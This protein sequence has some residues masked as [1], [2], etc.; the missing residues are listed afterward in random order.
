MRVV[1]SGTGRGKV[2]VS[3]PM[4]V[5][6]IAALAALAALALQAVAIAKIPNGSGSDA[7][8]GAV[9]PV[10]FKSDFKGLKAERKTFQG[11]VTSKFSRNDVPDNV[12]DHAEVLAKADECTAGVKVKLYR[13]ANGEDVLINDDKTNKH[14]VFDIEARKQRGKHYYVEVKPHEF[15]WWEYYN[16][17]TG[18]TVMTYGLCEKAKANF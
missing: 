9:P 10:E 17:A 13:V 12:A 5:L 3:G 11:K 6:K 7:Q 18:T 15:L 16:P 1:P 4:R 14:G 8:G 2:Q